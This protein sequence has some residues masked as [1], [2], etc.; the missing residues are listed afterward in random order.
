L[1]LSQGAGASTPPKSPSLDLIGSNEAIALSAAW[2]AIGREVNQLTRRWQTLETQMMR[3]PAWAA[4]S[5][6]ERRLHP[7][8]VQLAENDDLKD[9]VQARQHDVLERLVLTPAKDVSGAV[10]KLSVV[11]GVMY[12]DD[13]PHC[14]ELITDAARTLA[15][16][17][18]PHCNKALAQD[19][20]SVMVDEAAATWN[21]P[22]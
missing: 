3:D 13:Y 17:T 10:G 15:A 11:M 12:P 7:A 21:I 22:S 18:C 9:G 4:L 1:A 6:E 2:L 8:Q 20:A 14:Y 5:R 16:L 19:G